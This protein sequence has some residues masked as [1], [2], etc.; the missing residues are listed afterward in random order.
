MNVM[1]GRRRGGEY[2]AEGVGLGGVGFRGVGRSL[3]RE[4][5]SGLEMRLRAWDHGSFAVNN[6][7]V[8]C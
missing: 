2:S 3:W 7:V 1:P 5:G 6:V 4:A 8:G